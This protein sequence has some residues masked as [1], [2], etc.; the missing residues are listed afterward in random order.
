[1]MEDFWND[2]YLCHKYSYNETFQCIKFGS[3]ESADTH[4]TKYILQNNTDYN[5]ES[6]IIPVC[7]FIPKMYVNNV[8][9]YKLSKLVVHIR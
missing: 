7:K 4:Y 9:H 8:I 3:Y 6:F 5:L 1:M 2:I